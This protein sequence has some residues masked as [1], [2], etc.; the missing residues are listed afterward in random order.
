MDLETRAGAKEDK[1]KAAP[2]GGSVLV[3]VDDGTL[4]CSDEQ[5]EEFLAYRRIFEIDQYFKYIEKHTFKTQFVELTLEEGRAL[6]TRDDSEGHLTN[7]KRKLDEAIAQFLPNGAFVRLS[8]RSP[9]DAVDKC[10]P[11]KLVEQIAKFIK[12]EMTKKNIQDP[13][14]LDINSK[15]ICV[16]RAFFE[17]MRV[18][19]SEDVFKLLAVSYRTTGDLIRAVENVD[20]SPWN[21]K[22]VVREFVEMPIETEFR[23]FVYNG[24]LNALSQYYDDTYFNSIDPV[25]MPKQIQNFFLKEVREAGMF[26]GGGGAAVDDE[27]KESPLQNYI[28]DFVIMP[29]NE[30][31]IVELNPFSVQTGSCRFHW[32]QDKSIIENGPFEFRFR[33]SPHESADLAISPWSEFVSQAEDLIKQESAKTSSICRTQ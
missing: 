7:V 20:V 6:R 27:L 21:M 3:T 32:I 28:M 13:E 10:E 5:R 25:E 26:S 12:R 18:F 22:F 11:E 15:L 2:S 16:R 9:K 1:K 31:K 17:R 14:E 8:T 30:V 33:E 29:D 23:G 24:N 4:P 19:S